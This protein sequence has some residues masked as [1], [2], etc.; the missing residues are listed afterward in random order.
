M[1]RIGLSVSTLIAVSALHL[2]ARGAGADYV[3]VFIAALASWIAV[4]GPGE[5]ALIAAGLS[6]AHGH[7]DLTSVL[8]VAWAGAATG[9]NA[10]WLVGLKAGRAALTAAGPLR[11]LRLALIDRG[12]RF[13]E[14]YGVIAALFTPTWISGIHHMRWSR[15]MPVNAVSTLA[16]TLAVGIGAYLLGPS[17]TDIVSDAGL[18]GGLLVAGLVIAGIAVVMRRRPHDSS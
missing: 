7:L 17:I 5:A 10:G 4:P 6:A 14:R 12:D 18:A 8:A 3:G 15:F 16:W 11:R 9:G 2:H 1:R 13:Y